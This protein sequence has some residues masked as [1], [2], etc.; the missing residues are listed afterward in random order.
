M[1]EL[2]GFQRDLLY[3]IAAIEEPY[4][5]EIKRELE[6]YLSIDVN[7]GRLYPNLDQLVEEGLLRKEKKDDRTN[8]YPLTP[9]AEELF[10]ERREWENEMLQAGGIGLN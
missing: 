7:H 9:L 6:E 4:G 2:T 8:L 3:C 1:D 10:A 5:L